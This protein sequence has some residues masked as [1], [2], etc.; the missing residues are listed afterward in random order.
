M[1]TNGNQDAPPHQSIETST[2]T[3]SYK[4][5][6]CRERMNEN[7]RE[8][9]TMPQ[10][11]QTSWMRFD[12][13][14]CFKMYTSFLLSPE[15]CCIIPKQTAGMVL[16][17][18]EMFTCSTALPVQFFPFVNAESVS[19]KNMLGFAVFLASESHTLN[20]YHQKSDKNMQIK[21][22]IF[23]ERNMRLYNQKN[24]GLFSTQNWV[25]KEWTQPS[26]QNVGLF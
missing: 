17:S 1:S 11:F 18:P 13:Y 5:Q 25:E 26:T 8:M 20:S 24:V 23:L 4:D 12:L 21:S 15:L 22:Q 10:E 19:Q 6:W 16:D 3:S 14:I 9:K 7:K 2:Y